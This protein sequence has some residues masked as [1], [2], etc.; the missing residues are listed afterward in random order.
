MNELDH[1]TVTG[2]DAASPPSTDTSSRRSML[3][4]VAV[5]AAAAGAASVA[6][7]G[8][9]A[10]AADPDDLSL[11]V[12]ND[13]ATRTGT[14]YGGALAP[15]AFNVETGPS[16][17]NNDTV[18]DAVLASGGTAFLGVANSAGPQQVGVVGWSRKANGT[19]VV[20]FTGP[21]GAYGGEFFGGVAEVRLRPG[22]AAPITLTNAH[23]VGELYEDETGT[24]WICIAAGSP[25]TWR[26]LAGPTSS[27]AF[28]AIAPQRVYDSRPDRKLVPGTDR[29][30]SVADS[31][32][33]VADVVPAGATAVA[34]TIT[35][36]ETE[37]A[38]GGF[39]SIRPG[40][41]PDN[42]TSSINWW[43]V[44]QTLATTVIVGVDATRQLIALPGPSATHLIIDVTG[45]YR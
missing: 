16:D 44:G 37:G 7:A 3:R 4:R 40:D 34:A 8:R 36:T 45:Y 25:G 9:P 2:D 35:V 42:G 22:G 17:A 1:D 19:G 11:L 21:A 31:L 15:T 20:G 33:G 10:L 32:G 23:Q 18:L 24:L 12:V 28:H 38:S 14:R 13:H 29:V 6:V 30:I 39:V 41:A 26:E 27:G 5:S 43:G